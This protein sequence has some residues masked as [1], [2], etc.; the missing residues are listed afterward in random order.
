MGARTVMG[1]P[2]TAKYWYAENTGEEQRCDT[3]GRCDIGLYHRVTTEATSEVVI[4]GFALQEVNVLVVCDAC[5]RRHVKTGAASG[6][7]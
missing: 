7:S 6:R 4:Q 5:W 2:A 3:C 1:I